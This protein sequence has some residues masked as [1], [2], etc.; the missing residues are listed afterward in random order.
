MT[1]PAHGEAPAPITILC[2][3]HVYDLYGELLTP[4]A[5]RARWLLMDSER[6]LRLDGQQVD[7]AD[8][9]ADVG[10]LTFDLVRTDVGRAMFKLMSTCPGLAWVQSGYAGVNGSYWRRFADSGVTITNSHVTAVP[11]AEF[12]MRSVLDHFQDVAGLERLRSGRIWAAH[13]FREVSG[14]RWAIAGLGA[15]GSAIAERARAFGAHVTGIRR[16]P[17]GDEPVDAMV[18]RDGLRAVL[19]ECDVVVLSLPETAETIGYLG[20]DELALLRPDSV[21]VN[22][23]RGSA[24]DEGALLASLDAGRPEVAVLDVVATEPLPPDHVLWTHPRVRLSPHTSAAGLGRRRRA[25][26]LFAANLSRWLAGD[27]LHNV[28]AP[29]ELG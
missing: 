11:I 15:I 9:A 22:V 21:V 20:A 1:E 4:A 23:G 7:W 2:S 17:I 26:E 3:Q 12:V 14:T 5:P 27:P 8:A 24:I 10:W 29:D 18:D 6:V 16:H 28:V 13:D 25:A 19:P